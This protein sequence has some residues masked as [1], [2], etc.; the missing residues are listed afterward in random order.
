MNTSYSFSTL[1]FSMIPMLLICAVHLFLLSSLLVFLGYSAVQAVITAIG[2]YAVLALIMIS[3][4]GEF[5]LRLFCGARSIQREDWS[6]KA[7][8]A[9][10]SVYATAQAN[11]IRIPKNVRLYYVYSPL[12]TSFSFGRKTICLSAGLL[13]QNEQ[14]I[15]ALI[16]HEFGHIKYLDSTLLLLANVGNVPWLL[17]GSVLRLLTRSLQFFSS[18]NRFRLMGFFLFLFSALLYIP[19]AVVWLFLMFTRLVLSIGN[20]RKEYEA[21]AFCVKLGYGR[22]LRCALLSADVDAQM[23]PRELWQSLVASHPGVYDR[24]GRIDSLLGH[25]SRS[26]RRSFY[27]VIYD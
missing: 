27:E 21:D 14:T 10:G 24:V 9:L 19:R 22:E 3:P 13:E 11:G 20:R 5:L 12:Q 23:N 25:T 7:G 18:F 8:N 15:E 1:K 6:R 4:V 16:A 17:F 2:V 26:A